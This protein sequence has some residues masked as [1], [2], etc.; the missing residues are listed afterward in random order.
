MT[1]NLKILKIGT[2]LVLFAFLIPSAPILVSASQP[3]TVIVK[4]ASSEWDEAELLAVY[5][6]GEIEPLFDRTYRFRTND[7]KRAVS[8][9]RH[10]PLVEF[11]EADRA[12]RVEVGAVDELFTQDPTDLSKQWYLP[13]IK[14]PEAWDRT[15][16][17]GITVAVI[18]TGIDGKHEDL[19]DGRVIGGYASYCQVANPLAE[20]DCLVRISSELAA[21]VN[22][23]DNGHGTI[24]SG[25]IGAIP[26][27]NKGITGIVWN[28]LL[29]PIKVLDSTGTGLASD[30]A[31]GMK[32][33]V[34]HG[35]RVLNMSI[36]GQGV[37]GEQVI[38]EAVNYVYDK[39][40][41]IVA[42]AGNDA[43]GKGGNL[44][45][46]GDLNQA[47][48]LPVCAD[49][50]QNKV[51][52]VAAVDMEDRKLHF[53]NYGGNCIDI[54]APGAGNYIDRNNRRGLVSTYYDPTQPG[55]QNLY[56]YALGTS[57]AAPMVSGVAALMLSIFPELDSKAI[58]DRIILGTD[59]IDELNATA[60]N[61]GSCQGQIGRGRL[62]AL[63]AVTN[64][65][66]FASGTIV[67][68]SDGRLYLIERG[69]KR[70]ISERVFQ[71]RFAGTIPAQASAGQ[72]EV[73]PVG[74]PVVPPDGVLIKDTVSQTVYLVEGGELHALSYLSFLSRKLQF[75]LVVIFSAEEVASFPKGGDAVVLNG[76]ALK[77]ADHPAVY[78]LNN[79]LKQLMSYFVFRLRGFSGQ[80]VAVV[81]S[82]ELAAYPVA[83]EGYLFPPPEGTLFRGT[84]SAT[85]YLVEG[86]RRHGLTSAVFQ[87][88]GYSFSSV[89]VVPQGEV[90]QYE[91][92]PDILQ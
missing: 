21:G 15:K 20:N 50:G 46:G 81:S 78:V 63:K 41:V 22:S 84:E 92:G 17:S 64:S 82:V 86:G 70:L 48:I 67:R 12:V 68:S 5:A 89:H 65:P 62:N 85:V 34:D 6:I 14:A 26:N 88:R 54:S 49:G 4:L 55:E 33:A 91:Q 61:S 13:K 74:P 69:L 36:G 25:I 52:G 60:C 57:V 31:V 1:N 10:S 7:L 73:F 3:G 90:G 72:L 37:G 35:A 8:A 38:Q 16:G 83:E 9:L 40:A 24:V 58:R 29:M 32:W 23:D 30:V 2:A 18:D 59:S 27:N 76:A 66:S 43:A 77:S 47:P 39:G 19:N 28:V 42:A 56:V 71:G 44:K 45:A 75:N 11:A 79:G 53:S 51:I 80:S 87:K